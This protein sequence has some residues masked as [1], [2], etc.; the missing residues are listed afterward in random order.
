MRTKLATLTNLSVI[1]LSLTVSAVLIKTHFLRPGA[2]AL[3]EVVADGETVEA[4][5]ALLPADADEAIILAL[6]PECAFCTQSFPFYRELQARRDEAR[7][8]IKII[9]AVEAGK[10][11]MTRQARL[12][13]EAGIV[14]D[15]LVQADFRQAKLLGT[16]TVLLVERGGKVRKVWLG[17]LDDQARVEVLAVVSS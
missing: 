15:H 8:G 9:A 7:S 10:D 11:F 5:G 16:P 3:P 4:L 6:S 12:L 17:Q 2:P 14:V 1:I 13:E